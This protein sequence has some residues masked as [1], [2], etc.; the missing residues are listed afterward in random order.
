MSWAEVLVSE[1]D[2]AIDVMLDE[3][4]PLKLEWGDLMKDVV[5]WRLY[6]LH[7][8]TKIKLHKRRQR[9]IQLCFV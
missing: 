8:A 2:R 1:K 9:E 5:H 4:A 6:N 3:L 7:K